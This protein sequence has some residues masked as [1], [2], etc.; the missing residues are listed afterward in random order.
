M[1]RELPPGID[2]EPYREINGATTDRLDGI[3]W[4]YDYSTECWINKNNSN[5]YCPKCEVL[6]NEYGDVIATVN[7]LDSIKLFIRD[8]FAPPQ[9]VDAVVTIDSETEIYNPIQLMG[10]LGWRFLNFLGVVEEP[11]IPAGDGGVR[12]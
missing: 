5:V 9:K 7:A 8:I 11:D 1:K 12:G 10:G 2:P 3:E 4:Y 6:Y